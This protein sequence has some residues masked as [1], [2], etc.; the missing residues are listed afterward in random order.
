[1]RSAIFGLGGLIFFSA[2]FSRPLA[3][4]D[5]NQLTLADLHQ[6]CSDP[7]QGNQIACQY[8]ILG[9]AEGASAAAGVAGDK[10]HFC[11][12]TGLSSAAMQAAVTKAMDQDLRAFPADGSL[13][14]VTFVSAVML[15]AYPCQ[16][17]N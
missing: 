5:F 1:M 17:A 11:I 9:V 12:P 15:H 10:S 13:S 8:Y 16:K 4:A 2:L 7:D 14:A 6:L 3:A